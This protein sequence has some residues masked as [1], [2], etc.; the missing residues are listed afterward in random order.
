MSTDL[1][2]LKYPIG[3]F[4]WP[5]QVT[6]NELDHAY[7]TITTFPQMMMQAVNGLTQE[8]LDTPY[9]PDG[10]TIRQ[11]VHHCADSHMNAVIRFKLALTED[12]PTI[13][14]YKE[15]EWAKL[16]DYSMTHEASIFI[17]F[18]K[19]MGSAS[20]GI[21]TCC[22]CSIALIKI[23]CKRSLRNFSFSVR[24]QIKG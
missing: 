7:N 14:P 10:W 1:E 22:D 24:L 19:A 8:Q 20:L 6:A 4:K 15:A 17:I 9:R 18:S 2:T 5:E 11:V 21:H 16:T 23:C 12:G 3:K 13:K